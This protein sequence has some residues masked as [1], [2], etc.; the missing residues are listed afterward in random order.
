MAWRSSGRSNDELVNNMIRDGTLKSPAVIEAM[1]KVD[2]AN[3]VPAD[4]V[5]A[6]HEDRPLPIGY[7]QTISAP[8]MHA[9][10]LDLL[11][12]F[13]TRPDASVLDVGAGS[14]YLLAVLA[15]LCP[16][17]EI[18]GI[19]VVPELVAFGK[20]NLER[21]KLPDAA[22]VTLELGDGWRGIPDGSFDAIHVGAA[23]ERVPQALVAQ[24]KSP[25][26]MVVPVGP[27]GGA[28]QLLQ[29]DKASDGT[30]SYTPAMDVRFVPLVQKRG[31]YDSPYIQ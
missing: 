12:P 17:G 21:Q 8:H 5:V 9:F 16:Q 24:L 19:E 6:A 13:L 27:D 3:F 29:V 2:R 25:G 15:H 28:Q 22:R 11:A 7:L 1:R 4:I 14:G 20:S 10:A 26:R 23:A 31:E 30:V 18:R